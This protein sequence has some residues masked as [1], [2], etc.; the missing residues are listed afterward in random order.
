M[1]AELETLQLQLGVSLGDFG[2][3]FQQEKAYLKGL[4]SPPVEVTLKIKYVHALDQ[5]AQI[6]Q[7]KPPGFLSKINFSLEPR[8]GNCTSCSK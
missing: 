2:M 1:E 8:M 5:L 7:V 3:Y 6:R 4:Q